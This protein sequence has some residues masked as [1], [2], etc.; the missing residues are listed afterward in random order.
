MQRSNAKPTVKKFYGPNTRK[1]LAFHKKF[2]A[3]STYEDF[4]VWDRKAPAI[5]PFFTDV[6][7]NVFLDF[8]SHVATTALGYNHP[9]LIG[10]AKRLAGI[11]PDRYAGSD[12][13][14]GYGKNPAKMEIPTPSHLH[15]KLLEITRQFGFQ[16]SYFTNSGAEAVE[17]AIKLCYAT[18]KNYGYGFCFKGAFHGRTLGALSLNR[19]KLPHRKWYPQIPKII[20]LPYCICQNIC[21]CGWQT[22]S[23]KDKL[24]NALEQWLDKEIGLIA[25]EEVAFII[26]EPIQGEGGYKIPQKKFIQE[27]YKIARRNNIPII[28]DE[29]QAGMGRTGTWWAVEHFDCKPDIISAGKA[30]RI[31]A[32]IGKKRFFP[33]EEAR[34]SSTWGEGNAI[35]TA[36]GYKTIEIIQKQKLLKNAEKMGKY[37][38]K[39]LWEINDYCRGCLFDVRGIGLMIVADFLTKKDRDKIK[40]E[41]LKKGLLLL[42][43]GYKGIRFLPP[44]NVNK[45]EIDLAC[46][47]LQEVVRGIKR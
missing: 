32:T 42:S 47:V 45:R 35:A 26:L 36:I 40:K 30:L 13:I 28:S 14:S 33:T 22:M 23:R 39:R 1:W 3:Q 16:K 17:N 18:R 6:D 21:K 25:P 34:I 31:G 5:G 38:L 29:V 43:C 8:A 44:L 46:N 11:D 41:C 27:V 10:V 15:K 2:A 37:F 4:I 20:S 12:F 7:G 24:M 19:S 9:Q